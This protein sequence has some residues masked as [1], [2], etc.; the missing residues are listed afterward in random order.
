MKTILSAA[1]LATSMIAAPSAALAQRAP[2]ATI[3]V[4]DTDRIYRECNACRTAATQ[5]Q[6]QVTALQNRQQTLT[7]QLR[8]EGQGI[9]T[10][11]QALNGKQPDAALQARAR[12]F[13]TK[14]EQ[15]QQELQRA[16]QNIQSIQANVVRQINVRLN[17]AITQVMNAQGANLALDVNATLAHGP[18]I[19]V[20]NQVLAALNA[21]LPSVSVT[22]LPQQQQNQ[23]QPQGR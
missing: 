21:S 3:V 10:A 13:E 17:P 11:A 5:L 18:A 4:V 6:S 20:T 14:Q 12:A 8:T 22:P 23:T 19:N 1:L 15:A 9:Q 16:Q 2:A 7:N